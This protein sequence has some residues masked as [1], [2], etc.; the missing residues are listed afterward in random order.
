M[1]QKEARYQPPSK[2]IGFFSQAKSSPLDEGKI[3]APSHKTRP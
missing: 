2:V 1:S 3:S